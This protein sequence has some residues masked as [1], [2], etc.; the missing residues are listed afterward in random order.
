MRAIADLFFK[1]AGG[2]LAVLLLLACLFYFV[3]FPGLP[4]V[5]ALSIGVPWLIVGNLFFLLIWA[6]GRNRSGFLPLLALLAAGLSFGFHAP[7]GKGGDTSAGEGVS[8]MTYNVRGF[9]AMGYFEPADAGEQ[10]IEFII[11]QDPDIICIQEFNRIFGR[12]MPPYKDWFVTPTTSGNTTQ[13]I[14]SKYPILKVGA[15][16]FPGSY[17]N[18]IF[19]DLRIEKDTLRVYNVHLESFKIGSREFLIQ[20]HG[21]DFAMR[22]NAVAA[23]QRDQAALVKAHQ[24][25][26]PYPSVI[27]GDFNATAFSRPYRIISRGLQDSFR[28][29]GRGWGATYFLNQMLPYRIDFILASEGLQILEHQNF[30]VDLSDHLPVQ[31]VLQPRAD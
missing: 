15:V 19:A 23:R 20:N 30:E 11:E 25:A 6:V 9:N 13:A 7:F 1:L 14:Y 24:E 22:L 4:M 2:V 12:N 28:E 3:S 26:S 29:K 5:D 18:A 17:N 16:P 21:Q 8:I 27:C 10:I 31:A